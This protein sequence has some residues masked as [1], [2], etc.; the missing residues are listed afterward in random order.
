[1]SRLQLSR[2]QWI[3]VW[4]A[5]FVCFLVVIIAASGGS[6]NGDSAD[7]TIA[8]EQPSEQPA[9]PQPQQEQHPEPE[10]Q[11]EPEPELTTREKIEGCLS[12][13]DGN[14]DGFENQIRPLLNDE[15]SMET[16]STRFTTEPIGGDSVIIE[17]VY[18]ALNAYGGRVKTTASGFLNFETCAV[19]VVMTGLE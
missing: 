9:S 18:S 5:I 11:P 1:M 19:S 3:G 6:Q 4:A 17:M 13:W 16:H 8:A 12:E 15:G 14:H 7:Q 2:K 10:P